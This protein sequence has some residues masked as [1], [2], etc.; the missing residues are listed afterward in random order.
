[1]ADSAEYN[2]LVNEKRNAQKQYNACKDRIEDCN[3]LIQR[4]KRAKSTLTEQKS[5]Y[6]SIKQQDSATISKN[7]KWEGTQYNRFK[8]LGN[9]LLDEDNYYYKNEI[10]RVL[11]S[12]NDEITRLENQQM[13]DYGVLGQLGSWINSL[14][15]KIENFFN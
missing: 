13:K 11:D 6:K 1:M 8:T 9:S 12:I 4:L 15:N 3:Y 10:D 14:G 2:K 5:N 7:Y